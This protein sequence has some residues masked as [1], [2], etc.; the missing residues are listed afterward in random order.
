MDTCYRFCVDSAAG[1]HVV[2]LGELLDEHRGRPRLGALGELT[3]LA[4]TCAEGKRLHQAESRYQ[5][6]YS[7][8]PSAHLRTMNLHDT[9]VAAAQ[10]PTMVHASCKQRTLTPARAASSMMSE[11]RLCNACKV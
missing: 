6:E 7:C 10:V 9:L 4:L 2:L 5:Y 3:P 1:H 8:W 11:I